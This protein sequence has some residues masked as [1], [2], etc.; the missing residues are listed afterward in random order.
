M[1]S[2]WSIPTLIIV[3]WRIIVSAFSKVIQTTHQRLKVPKQSAKWLAISLVQLMAIIILT[4]ATQLMGTGKR[5]AATILRSKVLTNAWSKSWQAIEW[6]AG[7]LGNWILDNTRTEHTRTT[8]SR[9]FQGNHQTRRQRGTALALSVL[10][11]QAHAT[12]A[13]ERQTTFDTDSETVGIDNRCSGCISHI[14]DDF[15]GNLRPSNRLVKGFAGSRTTNVQVGTLR[16]RW[17]DYW[18]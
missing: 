12:V 5:R 14:R 16:W 2:C 17:E 10:A 13:T 4:V 11:M 1:L 9:C 6:I 18:V 3:A 15:V 8:R 7:K